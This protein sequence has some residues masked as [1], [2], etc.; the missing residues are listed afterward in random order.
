MEK[1]LGIK[2]FQYFILLSS[3]IYSLSFHLFK[4][5]SKFF[6]KDSIDVNIKTFENYLKKNFDIWQKNETKIK[7]KVLITNFI[8]HPGYTITE[9]I[10]GKYV[11]EFYNFEPYGLIDFEDKFG[12]KI[13]K[14]FKVDNFIYH[15]KLSIFNRLKYLLIAFIKIRNIKN[16]DEFIT[17][18]T[19][20]INFGRCVY[21]HILRHTGS[22]TLEKINFKVLFFLSEA[23]FY[24][25]FYKN[26]FSNNNFKYL[27]MSETQFL[28][29]NIIFQNALQNNIKVISRIGGTKKISARLFKSKDETFQ[30]NNKISKLQLS[31]AIENSNHQYSNKGFEIIKKLYDGERKHHDQASN[32][33]YDYK[34]LDKKTAKELLKFFGWDNTKKICTIYSHNLYDGN[35]VNEWRIFRDNLTWLRKTLIYI[36]ENGS[37]TNWIIKDHPSDYGK[38]RSKNITT[39]K[40]FQS[41]IG[42][43]SNIKFFPD[44][45]KTNILKDVTD[46]L[47]T[48]QGSAGLEY[49]CFGI[50]SIIC[51]DAYYQGLGFTLEPKNEKDYYEI[52]NNINEVI[53]K[54]LSSEQIQKA[55]SAFY[56]FE[57]HIRADHPLLFD[58]NINRNLNLNDFFSIAA[59]KISNYNMNNDFWKKSLKNQLENDKRH[60]IIEN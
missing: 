45:F 3:I 19:N 29:S 54:G 31:E 44:K 35:Y 42:E 38:N 55:R 41:I 15:P 10:L 56:F 37:N 57:E 53:L 24:N 34:D 52:I 2:N 33:N 16:I 40:E 28:P 18:S 36:K 50:P 27:I 51:G 47:L 4:F 17:Y 9:S 6:K 1:K 23:I 25:D 7:N 20:N 46:C 43:R 39:L 49:P 11:S 58:Y 5:F 59:S 21:D 12:K 22:G 30:S 13:I 48:S 14:S 8:H 26:L 60:F 32:K